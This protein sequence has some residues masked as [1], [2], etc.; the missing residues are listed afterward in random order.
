MSTP[1]QTPS[2]RLLRTLVEELR[3]IPLPWPAMP[4]SVQQSHIDRMAVDVR[5]AL[6][7]AVNEIAGGGA[8]RHY[9]VAIESFAVKEGCKIVLT[10]P[11]SSENIEELVQHVGRAGILVLAPDAESYVTGTEAVKADPDQQTLLPDDDAPAAPEL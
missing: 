6:I 10:L 2:A 4:E 5:T 1:F 7:E 9:P 11:T 3:H 8:F